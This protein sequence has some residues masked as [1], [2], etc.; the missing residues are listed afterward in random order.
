MC[1]VKDDGF[2]EWTN[3]MVSALQ[4]RKAGNKIRQRPLIRYRDAR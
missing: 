2:R 4:R 3:D 1:W